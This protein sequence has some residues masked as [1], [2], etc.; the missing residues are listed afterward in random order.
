MYGKPVFHMV[1]LHQVFSQGRPLLWICRLSCPQQQMQHGQSP[2]APA[3]IAAEPSGQ[4]VLG[5]G[6]RDWEVPH[7][8][9]GLSATYL[10]VW[11]PSTRIPMSDFVLLYTSHTINGEKCGVTWETQG[12]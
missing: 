3:L 4:A 9:A 12:G 7:K 2:H 10:M 8:K 5:L 11:D 1:W 6:G